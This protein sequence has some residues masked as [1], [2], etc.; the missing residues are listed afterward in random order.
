MKKRVFTTISLLACGAA[1]AQSSV[2]LF[3]TIDAGIARISTS[4]AHSIGL[5]SGGSSTSRLGFRGTEDLGGGLAASFWLEGQLNNDTG[6]GATQTT[7]YDFARRSTVS[8][9]GGFGELRVGR[10]YAATYL[11]MNQFD[12]FGQRGV[13]S[14]ENAGSVRGGVASYSRASNGI[15]YF[16][17]N[18][19]GGVYGSVQYAFGEQVS[20]KAV[21]TNVL[22]IS[23]SATNASTIHT[24]GYYGGRV[25][26]A[27]GPFDVSASYGVFQ[28]GVRTVRTS[29]YAA[30]YKI[31]NLG[32][33]YDFGFVKPRVLYQVERISGRGT[34]ADFKFETLA[35]GV[36]A[37]VGS[38]GQ[39]RAQMAR[40][41]QANTS[42]DF[43]KYSLGYLHFLSKR[44]QLYVD[45]ARLNNKGA[46]TVALTNM[47]SS[48]AS[49][50][51]NAGGHSTGYIV[52]IKHM[53]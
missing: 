33:S 8:L 44:T 13:G 46:S 28:D 11:N 41:N 43:I 14:V 3:G 5:A 47:S 12:T 25:G 40:Y 18:S 49:P 2:T 53:F 29:F 27:S 52:G 51:P 4:G 32:A 19:L 35:I 24:G 39:L 48:V 17:P 38:V 30:D 31:A 21:T 16:F 1:A 10:D 36:T 22:G 23:T 7:G 20:P 34:I 15:A 6:S 26:Y 45:I 37:P 42:D 9:S 50:T